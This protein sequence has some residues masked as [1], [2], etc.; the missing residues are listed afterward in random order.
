MNPLGASLPGRLFLA[1]ERIHSEEGTPKEDAPTGS[2]SLEILIRC[3]VITDSHHALQANP[4]WMKGPSKTMDVYAKAQRVEWRVAPSITPD[5][6]GRHDPVGVARETRENK[7]LFER[8]RNPL[9]A[10]G[11]I[12]AVELYAEVTIIVDVRGSSLVRVPTRR[13]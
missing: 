2:S 5:L 6:L 13:W 9:S 12:V 4:E 7:K 3:D 10:T 8:K 11:D 1:P